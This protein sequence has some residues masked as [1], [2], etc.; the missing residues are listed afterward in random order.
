MTSFQFA[1]TASRDNYVIVKIINNIVEPSN[2][3]FVYLNQSDNSAV[4]RAIPISNS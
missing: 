1:P 2:Q 3:L 4:S